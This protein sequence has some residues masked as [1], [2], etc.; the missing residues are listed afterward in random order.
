[1]FEDYSTFESFCQHFDS[2]RACADALYDARWP[3]G[4]RCP[5]CRHTRSY[6][7]RTRRLPL[8]ECCSC[9]HQTSITCGTIM[10]GSS[11]SLTRWFQA[12]Y[13]LSQPAGISAT[14]LSEIIQVT[15]KTAWLIA[16]KIRHA[17]SQA[18]NC[19][20]LEGIVQVGHA[21]YGYSGYSDAKQ[22]LLVGVSFDKHEQMQYIKM[23]QPKPEHVKNSTFRLIGKA[24]C[25]EFVDTHTDGRNVTVSKPFDKLHS[26]VKPLVRA[27]SD[28]LNETFH[29]IGP[30]HLQA[31]WDEFCFRLNMK[32]NNVASFGRLL[33]FSASTPVIIYKDLIREKP[34]LAVPWLV[35]GTKG[36]WKGSYLS[37]WHA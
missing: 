13:L 18:D 33:S 2:E 6:V 9:R 8:F 36:K 15:Y 30:K 23:K 19:E 34:V 20:P 32:W 29:G 28:W 24:G 11:T 37:L 25:D 7:I 10:E 17:I 1:M 35:W 3:N 4:F 5:E 31:Y 26:S 16:H 22:P 12:I 21:H 27:M 14:R